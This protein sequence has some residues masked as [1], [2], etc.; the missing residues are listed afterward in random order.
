MLD[1]Y[2]SFLNAACQIIILMALI[3]IF[4][5]DFL[6]WAMHQLCKSQLVSHLFLFIFFAKMPIQL[7]HNYVYC[8]HRNILFL[9]VFLLKDGIG[10]YKLKNNTL[11]YLLIFEI[12]FYFI[13]QIKIYQ[14]YKFLFCD[15]KINEIINLI[16]IFLFLNNQLTFLYFL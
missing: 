1:F 13:P 6:L 16:Y 14:R 12:T 2:A 15:K 7:Y 8:G 10:Y 5:N 4:V 11:A 9:L 3:F